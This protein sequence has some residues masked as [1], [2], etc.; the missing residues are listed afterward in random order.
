MAELEPVD[1]HALGAALQ[2]RARE[3]A[4]DA[5]TQET[6][7]L[8]AEHD[9]EHLCPDGLCI[10]QSRL[11]RWC[12]AYGTRECPRCVEIQ[13]N[14]IR[15][16]LQSA[17]F[18]REHLRPV[19]SRV[20]GDIRAQV[21][22][23][24]EAIKQRT[25]DGIGLWLVGVPGCGKTGTL[26]MVTGYAARVGI[27]PLYLDSG[28]RVADAAGRALRWDHPN[29]DDLRA[30]RNAELLILDD[31]DRAAGDFAFGQLDDLANYRYQHNLA[32]CVATNCTPWDLDY[33]LFRAVSRW[34]QKCVL[35]VT[36]EPSQR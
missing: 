6:R 9:W 10:G 13:A 32:T 29:D 4:N 26:A 22:D 30:M 16:A 14:Q 35:L 8:L 15:R 21:R 19:W 28:M 20:P 5:V 23:Y 2:A 11:L 34:Q 18:G 33:G 25:A 7:R 12:E 3:L 17:G 31:V 36:T 27:E 24:C 1:L